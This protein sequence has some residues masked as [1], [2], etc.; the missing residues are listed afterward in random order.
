[1]RSLAAFLITI[2]ALGGSTIASASAAPLSTHQAN[3]TAS[4]NICNDVRIP[5]QLIGKRPGALL[6]APQDVTA[7]SGLAADAGRLYR[8]AY[9]TTGQ[10]GRVVASCGLI[11]VPASTTHVAGVI[12]WAHGTIGLLQDC[13]V[14]NDPAKFVG[15]MP[16]GIGAVTKKGT[17]QDGALY[18]MLK[19]GYAVVATD[20][21]AGGM[22]LTKLQSYVL[23]V[24]AGL[25]VLDS[26]RVLTG[27]ANSFGLDPVAAN[28]RL[29]LVTW[30]HSQGGGAALWAGQLARPYLAA[31]DD[32][33]LNL[34]GVAGEAPASQFTTSPGQPASY[35]GAHLGDR[36]MYNMA[37]GLG[38]PLPIGAILFSYVT[39]SWSDI[40]QG[41]AGEFPVG[42]TAS[43]DYR[44]ALSAE[45]QVT[46][47]Q[48]AK[49]CLT[50]SGALAIASKTIGYLN[51]DKKRLFAEPFAGQKVD[52]A[53]QGG[54]D[55]T[56]AAPD[57]QPADFAEWC[58]WL[59]F[60][61]PG[62][63]GV[64]PYPK[65]PYDSAGNLVPLMI[66]QG[67]NDRIIWCVDSSGA[68]Q[69]RNCLSAQ[70]IHAL[71]DTYCD[72]AHYLDAEYYPDISHMEIPSAAAR[73][74]GGTTYTGSQLQQFVSGAIGGTLGTRCTVDPDATSADR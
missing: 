72:G 30:G 8:V 57:Q 61:M 6:T 55:A 56:C 5:L 62:P 66:A 52:G 12:A 27:S 28:A 63:Y 20:Y 3:A 17:Q 21:P 13:Q 34:V 45:G 10:A 43:V 69:G 31:K 9:A 73:V 50:T 22:G 65:L 41:T 39:V 35:M 37:P 25:A 71:H 64:N 16:A 74:P 29:P 68:V 7:A 32:Q 46:A 70:Y 51:P 54:I 53:W 33:T 11:A 24:P 23:G 19:A 18:G 60:N 42:P 59:Q 2:A 15:P 4:S 40:T 67:S 1:M 38:V 48:V 26:A 44:T 58:R 49:C 14:S 47:P 36:D